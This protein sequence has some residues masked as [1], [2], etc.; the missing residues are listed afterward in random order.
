VTHELGPNLVTTSRVIARAKIAKATFYDLFEGREAALIYACDC[1][2]KILL[3]AVEA[4]AEAPG[5]WEE[6]LERT[7]GA[8]LDATAENLSLAELCIVH[9]KSLLRKQPKPYD[10]VLID[11]LAGLLGD[12]LPEEPE[13]RVFSFSELAGGAIVS[14]VAQRLIVGEGKNLS[15][16]RGELTTIV[17]MP[18]RPGGLAR[19]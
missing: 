19:V 1:G 14:I 2:R 12:I 18:Y 16:L 10:S 11:A 8:L 13:E 6:R 3:D 17:S 7:I 5:P 4:A 15:E 9:S